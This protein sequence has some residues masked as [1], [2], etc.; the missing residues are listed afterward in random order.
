MEG[1]HIWDSTTVLVT[2]DHSL[3]ADYWISTPPF[4]EPGTQESPQV[5][6]LLKLYG[7]HVGINYDAPFSAILTRDL[8][9]SILSGEFSSPEQLTRWLDRN[10]LRVPVA[11]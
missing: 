2:S 3:R 6:F 5:P 8:V 7:Q 4:L 10:R 9:L 11:N 1:A